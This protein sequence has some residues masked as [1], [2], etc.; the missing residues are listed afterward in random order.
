MTISLLTTENMRTFWA[1]ILRYIADIFFNGKVTAFPRG[2]KSNKRIEP[3]ILIK[4]LP[5]H[6]CPKKQEA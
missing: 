5:E 1:N 3:T 4:S 2:K 6:S